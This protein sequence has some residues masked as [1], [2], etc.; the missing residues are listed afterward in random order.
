M[1]SPRASLVLTSANSLLVAIGGETGGSA[2]VGTVEAYQPATNS[3]STRSSM[4][5]GAR[6]FAAGA[7]LNGLIYV[8]GGNDGSGIVTRL[9]SYVP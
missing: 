2:V 3:W 7:L 1:P 6:G 5:A 8:V 9:E 4:S